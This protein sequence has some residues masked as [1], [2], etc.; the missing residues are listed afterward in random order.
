MKANIFS[1][2]ENHIISILVEEIAIIVD[3][4]IIIYI[5]ILICSIIFIKIL[6]YPIYD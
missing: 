2:N 4:K 3:I 6:D 5:I 1:S